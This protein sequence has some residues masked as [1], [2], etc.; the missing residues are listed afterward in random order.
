VNS[1]PVVAL[2]TV[3]ADLKAAV[4]HYESWR[5][6]GREHVLRSY[7]E[8][9][10]WI[11]WNPDLFRKQFGVVRRAILKGSYYIVYFVQ[12][13]ERSVIVAVLDGRRE[14]AEIRRMLRSRRSK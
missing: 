7:E 5:Y 10:R 3:A 12:E 13:P 1:K 9:V 2:E 8:T 4:V 11:A 6:D 14:P